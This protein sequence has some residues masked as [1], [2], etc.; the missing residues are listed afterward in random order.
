MIQIYFGLLGFHCS[1]GVVKGYRDELKDARV[2]VLFL[3]LIGFCYWNNAGMITIMR[4]LRMSVDDSVLVANARNEIEKRVS[5]R[6]GKDLSEREAMYKRF[7]DEWWDER[8]K[9]QKLLSE[10]NTRCHDLE[11]TVKVLTGLLEITDRTITV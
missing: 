10:A 6:I 8:D 5:E 11:T 9:T 7:E 4:V 2:Y 1:G 3:G